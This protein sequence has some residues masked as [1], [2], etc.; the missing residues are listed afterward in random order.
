M[1]A[2]EADVVV[3]LVVDVV[4]VFVV[5]VVVVVVVEVV[6]VVVVEVVVVCATNPWSIVEKNKRMNDQNGEACHCTVADALHH[7]ERRVMLA[8]RCAPST[9]TYRLGDRE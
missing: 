1:D 2:I 8:Q 6:D 3:L 7:V 4:V 9:L 5:V